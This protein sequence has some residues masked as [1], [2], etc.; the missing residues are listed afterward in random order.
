ML[1]KKWLMSS[2]GQSF[3]RAV[4]EIIEES[5]KARNRPTLLNT[6]KGESDW[7]EIKQ[8]YIDGLERVS[9]LELTTADE[10]K[11]DQELD[12]VYKMRYDDGY[13][14]LDVS[15][16]EAQAGVLGNLTGT[17]MRLHIGD[18][19]KYPNPIE[20]P[21]LKLDLYYLDWARDFVGFWV[22]GKY[23]WPIKPHSRL[24]AFDL[25]PVE[26]ENGCVFC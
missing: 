14:T 16:A 7:K 17:M 12:R 10:K 13:D 6:G 4:A 2:D 21:T 26:F 19:G 11:F 5:R 15:K 25:V 22:F 9:P 23:R 20:R 24:T 18:L 8:A 3:L 1:D